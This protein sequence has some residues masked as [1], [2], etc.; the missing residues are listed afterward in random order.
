MSERR[1][2]GDQESRERDRA[3]EI[4]DETILRTGGERLVCVFDPLQD[5]PLGPLMDAMTAALTGYCR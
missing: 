4:R 5:E 3:T 1:G 2:R